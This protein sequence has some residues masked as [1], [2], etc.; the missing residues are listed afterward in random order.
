MIVTKVVDQD[1]A[2]KI[3]IQFIEN[4]FAE[5]AQIAILFVC[6]SE[7]GEDDDWIDEDGMRIIV[8]QL[9]Y[10]EVLQLEDARPLM[11]K[12]TKQRLGAEV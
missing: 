2:N 6:T 5:L 1:V 4:H 11:L 9:P 12:K 7:G 10:Q 3:D 8:I